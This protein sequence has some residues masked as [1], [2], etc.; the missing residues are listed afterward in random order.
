[1]VKFNL[2][3]PL[4]VELH[5]VSLTYRRYDYVRPGQGRPVYLWRCP[6]SS[7]EL[8]SSLN[9]CVPVPL[10]NSLN[11]QTPS[12]WIWTSLEILSDGLSRYRYP[13]PCVGHYHCV[14]PRSVTLCNLECRTGV[15][16]SNSHGGCPVWVSLW[17]RWISVRYV[18]TETPVSVINRPSH[19]GMWTTCLCFLCPYKNK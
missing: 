11:S 5:T 2:F 19:P 3:F 16:S 12:Q 15:R 17:F 14:P 1:M 9:V 6:A 4:N 7:P 10:P 13:S 8:T 18:G